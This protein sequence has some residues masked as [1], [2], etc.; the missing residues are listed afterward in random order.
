VISGQQ[1]QKQWAVISK[2]KTE[3]RKQMTEVLMNLLLEADKG[4]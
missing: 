2:E 1:N 3:D 4:L